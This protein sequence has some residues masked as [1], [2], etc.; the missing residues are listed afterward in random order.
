VHR[1]YLGHFFLNIFD[2]L[3]D[4]VTRKMMKIYPKMTRKHPNLQKN[5]KQ[6]NILIVFLEV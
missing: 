1:A 6:K 5:E 2:K 3:C 4:R